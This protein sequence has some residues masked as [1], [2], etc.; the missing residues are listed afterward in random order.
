MDEKKS[1][2][3][4]RSSAFFGVPMNS[5]FE[6]PRAQSKPRIDPGAHVPLDVN[7][8]NMFNFLMFGLK[9]TT[10][11][12]ST[13]DGENSETVYESVVDDATRIKFNETLRLLADRFQDEILSKMPDPNAQV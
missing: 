4:N 6:V 3:E 13:N 9:Q 1:A 7:D 11:T 10:V 2:E 5:P 8:F 12:K